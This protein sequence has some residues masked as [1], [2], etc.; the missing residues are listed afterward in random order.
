MAATWTPIATNTLSSNVTSL[1]FTGITGSYTNLVLVCNFAS[2]SGGYGCAI[3]VNETSLTGYT[4]VTQYLMGPGSGTGYGY[5]TGSN[6][7]AAW[8]VM[9]NGAGSSDFDATCITY[10][11]F[12]SNASYNKSINWRAGSGNYYE[13]TS[14]Y[15]AKNA[16]AAISSIRIAPDSWNT[17]TSFATGSTFTLYGVGA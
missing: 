7:Q 6:S 9:Y 2:L 4:Y 16:T 5:G 8:G 13:V 10:L 11:P 15:G 14:G 1:I 3:A 12:Y 17:R